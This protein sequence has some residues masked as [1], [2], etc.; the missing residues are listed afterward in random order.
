MGS[1]EAVRGSEVTTNRRASTG[2]GRDERRAQ[3][4]NERIRAMH[5]RHTRALRVN[6]AIQKSKKNRVT[7]NP[8][9]LQMC[10]GPTNETNTR[11]KP[12]GEVPAATV[13][14]AHV[15]SL[16]PSRFGFYDEISTQFS[17]FFHR[18]T[19]TSE[20]YVNEVCRLRICICIFSDI[21]SIELRLRNNER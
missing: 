18:K 5:K 20:M 19:R 8:S 16:N 13:L 1:C 21:Q 3:R 15:A 11:A 12:H 10:L 6:R 9:V 4:T 17:I 2:F 14:S 7:W